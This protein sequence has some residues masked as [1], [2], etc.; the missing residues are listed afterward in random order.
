MKSDQQIYKELAEEYGTPITVKD[1]ET[2]WNVK[3][4][5]IYELGEKDNQIW[6]CRGKLYRLCFAEL[7][8][9]AQRE[10]IGS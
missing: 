1:T 8:L 2:W 9:S 10:L 5:G 7:P 4:Y 3:A 6:T